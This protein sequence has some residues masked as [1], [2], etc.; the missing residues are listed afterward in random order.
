MNPTI[1]SFNLE[2]SFSLENIFCKD[3]HFNAGGIFPGSFRGETV[4]PSIVNI[5]VTSRRSNPSPSAFEAEG[6]IAISYQDY[7]SSLGVSLC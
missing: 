7:G 4:R 6:M 3:L 5:A 1:R 2:S